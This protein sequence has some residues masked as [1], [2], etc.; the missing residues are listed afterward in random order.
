MTIQWA[1]TCI[2]KYGYTWTVRSRERWKERDKETTSLG[3]AHAGMPE[4]SFPVFFPGIG[5][6]YLNTLDSM[7]LLKG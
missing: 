7:A 5:L 4:T 6:L 3:L 2:Y 1:Y